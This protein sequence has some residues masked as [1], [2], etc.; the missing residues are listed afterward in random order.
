MKWV[1]AVAFAGSCLGLLYACLVTPS[2][3]TLTTPPSPTVPSGFQILTIARV[4][5][6]RELAALP[7]G[8]LIVG[9][10]SSNVDIVPNAEGDAVGSAEVFATLQDRPAAGV[11]FAS[12]PKVIYVA[13]E[14]AVY[15]IPYRDG[16]RRASAITLIARVRIG[17]IAPN[18]DGDVHTTTSVAYVDGTL[19]ASVGSSCNAC[20]EVDP[21]RASILS[22]APRG[23]NPVKRAT[24]IR[25]AIALAVNPETH[26]LWAGDAG[27]DDLP[28]GHPYE[29]L[30]DVTSHPGV[31]DYGWPECEEN[32]HAYTPGANCA[33][34]VAPLIE[35]PAYSTFI[36]A[37]FYPRHQ[38]GTYVFPTTY[39]GALFATVHGS[40][41]RTSDG[42]YAAAPQV[43]VITMD[44]DRPR[45]PVNWQDPRAQ[46]QTF[47]GGFE[48][49]GRVRTG[50]PTGITVGPQGSLFVAD[51]MRGVIYRIRP[52]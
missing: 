42:A 8:D 35:V 28:F 43:V 36:G 50:R 51:D 34:T 27:Q 1:R 17:G 2:A 31:A 11:T 29:F 30:D 37:T 33:D 45:V 23:G 22:I 48:L 13:T 4:P 38:S 19:Y 9:T 21:T 52:K 20:T 49:G 41:H 12:A 26:A 40:W 14:H 44:G 46:W 16:E 25:N 18:S 32:H 3:Q 47:V 15:A 39:H 6:A 24:R 7:D 10:E 5:S